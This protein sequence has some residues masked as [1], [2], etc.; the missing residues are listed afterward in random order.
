[1][2]GKHPAHMYPSLAAYLNRALTDTGVLSRYGLP[3]GLM[4]GGAALAVGMG[5][6]F[7]SL[8]LTMVSMLPV[9]I[10]PYLFWHSY[11]S[12]TPEER[13]RDEALG[14]VRVLKGLMESRRLQRALDEASLT[15][16]DE[17]ARCWGRVHAALGNDAW[18]DSGFKMVR[19]QA[20]AAANDGMEQ[21]MLLYRGTVTATSGS[22]TAQSFMD[23]IVGTFGRRPIDDRMPPP[24]Y[25][26]ARRV[27][28]R[29]RELADETERVARETPSAPSVTHRLDAA[30]GELHAIHQAEEEL[31]ERL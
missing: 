12:R 5:S 31:R 15:V 10:S 3:L 1:M 29:M 17:A 25:A 2:F 19:D 23:E 26:E 28:E 18:A 8:P 14:M 20:R 27:C 30:L 9:L 11:R 22:W 24:A 7:Q 6:A 4:V 13:Q 21:I 16:M